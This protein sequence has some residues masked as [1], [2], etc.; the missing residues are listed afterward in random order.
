VDW[1]S[2]FT[3]PHTP[4]RPCPPN[5]DCSFCLKGGLIATQGKG[6]PARLRTRPGVPASSQ[7]GPGVVCEFDTQKDLKR[8]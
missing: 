3:P 8:S 4:Q 5:N 7:N 6:S 1:G 2:G